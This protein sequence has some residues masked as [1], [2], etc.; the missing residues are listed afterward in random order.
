MGCDGPCDVLSTLEALVPKVFPGGCQVGASA[1][2]VQKSQ[3][4]RKQV[5]GWN[6]AARPEKWRRKEIA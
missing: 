3:P 1:H 4:R 6:L 5:C 2:H